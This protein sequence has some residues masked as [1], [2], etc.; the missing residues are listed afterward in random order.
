MKH[1]LVNVDM[2]AHMTLGQKCV[3]SVHLNLTRSTMN[4]LNN[5]VV[6]KGLK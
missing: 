6:L 1:K 2:D 5:A 3:L 4:K